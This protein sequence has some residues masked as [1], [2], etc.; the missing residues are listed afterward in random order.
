MPVL[1]ACAATIFNAF[2]RQLGQFDNLL[3]MCY[4]LVEPK[5]RRVEQCATCC[6]HARPPRPKPLHPLVLPPLHALRWTPCLTQ[7]LASQSSFDRSCY[8]LGP[9]QI[10][11]PSLYPHKLE[12]P[13]P[14]PL[15]VTNFDHYRFGAG[16]S[17]SSTRASDPS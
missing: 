8:T 13:S 17:V 12:P 4:I 16:T 15:L 9:K 6:K 14:L 10:Q 11:L 1:N 2:L 5:A 3:H 7:D